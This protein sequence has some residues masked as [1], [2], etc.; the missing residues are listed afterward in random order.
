MNIELCG[1][2]CDENSL[3][4]NSKFDFS[5]SHSGHVRLIYFIATYLLS[6]Y[7]FYGVAQAQRFTN[8]L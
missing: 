5:W 4:I 1:C 7:A 2:G 6:F 8:V 3:F